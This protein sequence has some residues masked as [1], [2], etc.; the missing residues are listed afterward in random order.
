MAANLYVDSE[1]GLD[2]TKTTVNVFRESASSFVPNKNNV[3]NLGIMN[4][5][6]LL[7]NPSVTSRADLVFSLTNG[8]WDLPNP[9]QDIYLVDVT[10]DC[11]IKTGSIAFTTLSFKETLLEYGN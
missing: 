2:I 1:G 9:G 10:N 5:K 6:K 8:L 3:L 11:I 7:Y 4:S